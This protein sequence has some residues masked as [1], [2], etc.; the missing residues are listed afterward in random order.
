MSDMGEMFF[1]PFSEDLI[2]QGQ[3]CVDN[4]TNHDILRVAFMYSKL[5]TD[6]TPLIA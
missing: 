5:L 6:L 1:P 2:K 4:D 3:W